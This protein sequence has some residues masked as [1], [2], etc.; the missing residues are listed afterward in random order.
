MLLFLIIISIIQDF[1]DQMLKKIVISV[2]F[3]QV[4][5]IYDKCHIDLDSDEE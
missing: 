1:N 4:L 3:R 2:I 5:E